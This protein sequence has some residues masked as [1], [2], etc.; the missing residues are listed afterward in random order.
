MPSVSKFMNWSFHSLFSP[1]CFQDCI[2]WFSFNH[3][4]L[5]LFLDFSHLQ[6]YFLSSKVNV[7]DCWTNELQDNQVN[8]FSHRVILLTLCVVF[9]DWSNELETSLGWCLDRSV[10]RQSSNSR[11]SKI[12]KIVTWLGKTKHL[13]ALQIHGSSVS[14]WSVKTN[15]WIIEQH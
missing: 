2:S 7:T 5:L 1:L 4:S 14:F 10:N 8:L 9:S 12:E 15:R 6:P 11:I 13:Y 3:G